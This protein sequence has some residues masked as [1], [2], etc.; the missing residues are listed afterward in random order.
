[1]QKTC[2]RFVLVIG[3]LVVMLSAPVYSNATQNVEL[4]DG[5][6][7]QL[8][9]S[10]PICEMKVEANIGVL[11][12]LVFANGKVVAFDNISELFRYLLSPDTFGFT[13]KDLKKAFVLDH[14]SKKFIE[15]KDAVYV[16]GPEMAHMMGREMEAFSN[17]AAAEKFIGGNNDKKILAFSEV[18]LKDVAPKKKMLKMKH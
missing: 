16:I 7:I 13:P 1:M 11:G 5:S 10:C 2:R 12:A 8:P 15:A 3:V 14:D 4:P 6:K 9:F 18:S 17:K